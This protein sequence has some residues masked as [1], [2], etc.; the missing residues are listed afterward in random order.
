MH[1]A[2]EPFFLDG[3]AGPLFCLF[4][5]PHGTCRG[6]LVHVPP[7][8]EEMN[9]S[10]R[11]VALAA[12]AL[13]AQGIGV[14][15]LDLY[16]CGDSAGESG[17]ARWEGWKADLAAACA[18]L[19]ARL[20][21]PVGLWGL[22]LGALLALDYAR[23]AVHPPARL[24]LWQPVTKGATWLTQFL[25]L[26]LAGAMLQ[27]GEAEGGTSALRA[28]LQAGTPLQI[29]GYELAPALAAA[30]DGVSAAALAPRACPVHWCEV[31]AAPDRPLPP[32]AASVAQGW[33]AAGVD[34][35]VQLVDG[36]A[37]WSTPEIT[38][39]P[40][41]L[42]ASLQACAGEWP[43]EPA[44]A[45]P[46][47]LPEPVSAGAV[48]RGIAFSCAAARLY[49]V[50]HHPPA[51]QQHGVMVVVG[52]PQYRAGSHRQF[53]LLARTLARAGIPVLRFDYR[54]MGD[55]EG[56]IRGFEAVE[57]DL[58]A[59]LDAF[60][61]AVPGLERVCLW[62]L[63]DGATAAALYAPGDARVDGLALLNPWVRTEDGA[64]RATLKHYYRQ[65]LFDPRLWKKIAHGRFDLM[66]AL[67]SFLG[68]AG[69]ALRRT[70][71]AVATAEAPVLPLPERM[72]AAL[73]RF[74]GEILVMLS[75]ADLTAQEFAGLPAASPAWQQLLASARVV[76]KEL[77]KADHTC[78]RPEWQQ[79]VENWTRDWMLAR[80]QRSTA[81]GGAKQA[82]KFSNAP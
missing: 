62:G 7:F 10:R 64:A 78:S 65:R 1:P 74:D 46:A 80:G 6:A 16:G 8:G 55:S 37:F 71:P 51:A 82:P 45:R 11:M 28:T 50:L 5:P 3:P 20:G 53:T 34:L 23:D 24:L 14:L 31:V 26:R 54:G 66:G 40:A 30:I 49:G 21:R 44:A 17:E 68:L 39:A 63:C 76:R 38:E 56:G 27:E 57:A 9:R 2:A 73:R 58:R 67:A 75:G 12:R 33:R 59:A 19:S 42:E 15:Q 47:P 35:Q 41:L 4:H 43:P 79:Q 52:G 22:R 81:Q 32:A 69:K 70:A 77:P 72:L 18:W 60:F 36:P 48:E 29:A 25:R 13:A 61:A